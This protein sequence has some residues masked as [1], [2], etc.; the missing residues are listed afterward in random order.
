[1]TRS[2]PLS[3]AA[4]LAGLLASGACGPAK[5]DQAQ[6]PPS[7]ELDTSNSSPVDGMSNAQLQEQAKAVSPEQARQMGIPDSASLPGSN[8]VSDSTAS[9]AAR[10]ES[11]AVSAR[12]SSVAAPNAAVPAKPG[13]RRD[14]P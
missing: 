2:V 1:M 3:V 9:P 6:S 12:D 13:V 8:E 5:S 4:A 10:P 11:T 14:R 7:A